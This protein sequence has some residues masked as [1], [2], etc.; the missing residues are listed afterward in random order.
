MT[1]QVLLPDNG[2]EFKKQ[3]L[4]DICPEYG[5]K[6]TFIT[7]HHPACNGLV[8]RTNRKIL[9]IL[10]DL[11]GRLLEIWEE[12]PS[13]VVACKFLHRQDSSLHCLWV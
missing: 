5:V 7:A 13:Q 11:F 8:E 4:A 6:Q 3:A 12:W 10:R 1:P 2:S 9:E